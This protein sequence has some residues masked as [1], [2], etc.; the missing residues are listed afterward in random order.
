M[1]AKRSSTAF[2]AT[3]AVFTVTLLATSTRAVAQ[4]E[5][6]LY[7]FGTTRMDGDYPRAGLIFDNAGNL[8]GTTYSGGAHNAGSV[9]ELTHK[10]SGRW[11]E[12][13]LHNFKGGADGAFPA[14][15]LIFDAS[16]NLYGTTYAGGVH[17]SGTVFELTPEATVGW[18]EK[19]L[20]AFGSRSQDGTSP[21]AGLTLDGSGN[22]YGT[23]LEG[24]TG[25]SGTVF[26]LTLKAG[27]G[28]TEKV[29]HSFGQG[30][31][32]SSPYASLIIDTAG[33]LYGTT[34][35]GGADGLGT[36]FELTPKAGGKWAEK[37]LHSF[38]GKDGKNPTAS[39]IFDASGNLYGPTED[40]IFELMPKTGGGWA[41]KVLYN[42]GSTAGLIFDGAGR[43]YGTTYVGG[44]QGEGT[45]FEL[46][47]KADGKWKYLVVYSFIG[48]VDGA[49]PYAGL[50][51]DRSGNMYGTTYFGGA[52]NQGVVFEFTP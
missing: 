25:S 17:D 29:L 52:D 39:L 46:T 14:A 23:T 42:S 27:G 9:F 28:W 19:V 38:N 24:G 48:G 11:T 10:T 49:N 20:Y 4:K 33:N 41:E 5:K 6:L 22:L 34:F 1:Q 3:L 30:K 32:G 31:D 43:L 51:L 35:Y 50:A 47:R 7:S 45:V 26:E 16:G 12:R 13:I 44:P 37:V 15:N 18:T 40:S 21:Y 2:I 36:A 8:Y